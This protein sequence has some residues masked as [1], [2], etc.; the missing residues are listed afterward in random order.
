MNEN[1]AEQ[2]ATLLNARNNLISAYTKEKILN[3]RQQYIYETAGELVIAAVRL[4]KVQWY[5]AEIRHLVVHPDYEG[6]GF[7]RRMISLAEIRAKELRA[8]VMQCTIRSDNGG[9]EK[10]FRQSGYHLIHSFYY[11]KSK[12][13][14]GIWQK[15][16]SNPPTLPIPLE[17]SGE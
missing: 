4:K 11:P 7:G 14:L 9:A 10:T 2:I 15:T 8:R 12:H 1:Q 6:R 13:N 3:Y 5:Q 16:I 17:Y